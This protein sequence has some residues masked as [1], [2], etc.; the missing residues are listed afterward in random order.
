MLLE[1]NVGSM[2]QRN[3]QGYLP[4]DLL[5]N[6]NFNEMPL[7]LHKYF[8]TQLQ[9][10]HEYDFMITSSRIGGNKAKERIITN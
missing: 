2:I 5:H 4:S 3:K 1:N 7:H 8:N 9:E 6:L 10:L